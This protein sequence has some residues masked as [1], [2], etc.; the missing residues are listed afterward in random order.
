MRWCNATCTQEAHFFC[1]LGKGEAFGLFEILMFRM[2]CQQVLNMFT[3]CSQ[4]V[5]HQVLNMFISC[6]QCVPHQILNYVH[7]MLSM[8]SSPN[9]QL[10]SHHVLNVFLTKF[11]ICSHHVLN[12]FP[13]KFSICSHQEPVFNVCDGQRKVAY[14]KTKNFQM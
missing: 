13:T 4:C 14:Y 3:S 7:I 6:S 1:T 5:P 11:S 10:C 8:C 12:V 2:C 9:S